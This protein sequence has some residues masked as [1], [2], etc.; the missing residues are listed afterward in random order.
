[1]RGTIAKR[2]RKLAEIDTVGLP[3]HRYIKQESQD[4]IPGKSGYIGIWLMDCTRARYQLL[5]RQY[6]N[7]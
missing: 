3:S 2:L 4:T 7:A 5:K 6:K 1:M